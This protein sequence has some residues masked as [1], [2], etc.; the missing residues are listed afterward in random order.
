MSGSDHAEESPM[1]V[2]YA[3]LKGRDGI[4][5][6]ARSSLLKKHISFNKELSL[7]CTCSYIIFH[8]KYF[9]H[10]QIIKT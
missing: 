1:W 5:V 4:V 3:A 2:I 9:S 6:R 7:S 8:V 10:Y